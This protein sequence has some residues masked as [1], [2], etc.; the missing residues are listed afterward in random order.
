MNTEQLLAKYREIESRFGLPEQDAAGAVAAFI[1]GNYMAYRDVDFTDGSSPGI[2]AQMRAVI[3]ANTGFT[4]GSQAEKRT[5]YE[6]MAVAGMQ[7]ALGRNELRQQPSAALREQ[8]M[9]AGRTQLEQFL[10]VDVTRLRITEVGLSS[11]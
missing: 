4:S 8:M 11:L 1:A 3:E 6:Q 10:K 5:L 9:L 7:M 2:V